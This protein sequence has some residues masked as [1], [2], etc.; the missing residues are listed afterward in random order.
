MTMNFDRDLRL[1]AKEYEE[2]R[3]LN[4]VGDG[5]PYCVI[6]FLNRN[7]YLADR[8][9]VGY[10]ESNRRYINGLSNRKFAAY[11]INRSQENVYITSDGTVFHEYEAAIEHETWWLMQERPDEDEEGGEAWDFSC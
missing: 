6:S 2:W 5:S 1:L 11:T 9:A 10:P 4:P 8:R 7:G 3:K